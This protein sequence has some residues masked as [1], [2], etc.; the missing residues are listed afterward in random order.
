[1]NINQIYINAVDASFSTAAPFLSVTTEGNDLNNQKESLINALNNQSYL[2]LPV[3]GGF[4]AGK[5]TMLN[6]VLGRNLLPT[7]ITPETAV[8]YEL[9]YSQEEKLEVIENG[10]VTA[11]LPLENIQEIKYAPSLYVKVYVNDETIRS[12]NERGIV[13]VDMPGLDSGVEQHNNAIMEYIEDGTVFALIVDCESGSLT[14]SSITFL[15]EIRAYGLKVEVFIS[16]IEK[17]GEEI[18][19]VKEYITN[20]AKR[21]ISEDTQV[22]LISS[23]DGNVEEFVS[24]VNSVDATKC[25]KDRFKPQ[26]EGL[27]MKVVSA[28]QL[29]LTLKKTSPEKYQEIIEKIQAEKADA[30]A[31]LTK[32]M[33]NTQ[34]LDGSVEDVMDD[35]RV[36]L[37]NNAGMLANV[38]IRTQG[39]GNELQN[40]LLSIIRPVLI[41]SVRR[42]LTEYSDTIAPVLESF[43]AGINDIIDQSEASTAIFESMEPMRDM[44]GEGLR[45]LIARLIESIP[46]LKFI[47]KFIGPI[48][49]MVLKLLGNILDAIF[50]TKAKREHA[51][52]MKVQQKIENEVAD[53]IVSS[54]RPEVKRMIQEER[55][56]IDM[57]AKE[58]IDKESKRFDDEIEKARKMEA[59][60]K[61][62]R[63]VEI[64]GI[65]NAIS[66]IMT[67]CKPIVD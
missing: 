22:H 14:S 38:A 42:E 35:I 51:V 50:G 2:K 39:R 28:L 10:K 25:I 45:L 18:T 52:L 6:T 1:M 61:E 65:E 30:L 57:Q 60:D 5:S 37:L 26:V 36:A 24:F 62:K 15:N 11:T 9:Y 43:M 32:K 44:L 33:D 12:F 63:L 48:I 49:D 23:M 54:L 53:Q 17:K 46:A 21:Y 64:A 55:Q 67:I 20:Q 56:R 40:Q 19:S 47:A 4:N 8:A 41:N 3:V 29:Q 59:E 66:E 34:S 7:N 13:V 58:I 16:K 31:E 27:I